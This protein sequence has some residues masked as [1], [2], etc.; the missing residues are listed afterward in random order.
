MNFRNSL[1]VY[2]L[3]GYTYYEKELEVMLNRVVGQRRARLLAQQQASGEQPAE[4]A[5][6]II[7]QLDFAKSNIEV[8]STDLSDHLQKLLFQYQ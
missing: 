3:I 1:K 7:F 5:R 2:F 4:D 6:D 8:T